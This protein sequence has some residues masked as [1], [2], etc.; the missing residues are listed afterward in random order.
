[1][2][3]C[4][5][6]WAVLAWLDGEE[7][8]L[9]RVEQ[10]LEERPVISWVNLVEVYYRVA[11]D[12]DKSVADEVL[13]DLR[14]VLAP[15]LPGTARMLEVARLKARAPIALGDCFAVATAAAHDLPLLTG[16]PEIVD[17]DDPPCRVEDLRPR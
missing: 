1:V 11:R 5:D 3:A 16:D 12:Q 8:A 17:L 6:S 10:S 7:P 4:L 2:N 14:A 13:S 15:D 9:S